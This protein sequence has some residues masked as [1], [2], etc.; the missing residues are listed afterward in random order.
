[1]QRGSLALVSRKEGPD[2]WQFRWSEKDLHVVRVQRKRVIGTVERYPDGAAART[3]MT[4]VLAELNSG[5]A[6]I[7]RSS[8]TVAQLCDHFEQRELTRD[9]TWRSYSTKKTYQAY[10]N[11]W[12]LPH[13]RRYELAE[14]RTIQVESWLRHLPLAKSSCAKIRNLMSVLFNHACRYELFDRNPIYLVRQSAKRRRAPTVLMPDEIKAM[15]DNL[16]LRER[17]LVLLAVSTGL[18]QSELFAL[19]WGDIDLVQGT[20]NV[21]R[22]IVYGVVGPCKTESSQKPVPVHPLLADALSDWRKHCAYTKPDDW[23]FASKR[24]RGR[25]PYWG[26]AILR[27][28]LRP[29]AQRLGIQK[30][31]GWH[32]FR[33]TYST[34]L[35]SVGTEFK[36]MQ[37][38]LRHSTLR[39]TLDVYTQAITPAKHAAQA[40]VLSLVFSRE[41]NGTSRSL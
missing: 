27:K 19:K 17:T 24:H 26:Q 7:S 34:L 38:L 33:H 35:R 14:V 25:R 20:M 32:T 39:S 2:V 8:I 15:L 37:E 31:I 29:V 23:V 4:I 3:A 18:R 9:N 11:R 5:K 30:C 41:A 21:T 1:M 12:I 16:S 10:L 36:V 40:A 6:R 22:S 13:W 28:Y